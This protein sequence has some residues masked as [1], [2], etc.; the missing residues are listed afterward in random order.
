MKK[1]IFTVLLLI[2][3]LN[4]SDTF[5]QF[6]NQNMYLLKNLNQHYTTTL[7]AAVWGYVAPNGRE[8]AIL[9]CPTGTA[10]VDITDSANIHEVDFLTGLTSSWRE[11]KTYSHY[12]YIVSEATNSALQIVDLQ[13]L[14]DSVRLVKTWNYSGYT[15]THTISQSGHYLYLNGGN[16]TANGG[17]TVLDVIDPINPVKLG[18]WSTLYVHDCRVVND[19]IFAANINDAK[20]SIINA[21]NKSSLSSITSF[22]NLPGS[23]PHNT[24][25]T[26]N[27]KRLFVTDE[28]GNAP[29]LLKVWNIENLSNI[30]YVTSW[31]P[32]NITTSIVHNI[33]I[34]GNYALVAHYSAGVRVI[35]IS[36]P[37][38]PTE[39]AWYD[40]YP[41]NNN[42]SYNGCW[43]VYLFPSGK[44]AASDRQT[45]LY[46]LKTSTLTGI[47][48]NVNA[49]I[50][51]NFTLEQNYPNPF[52]PSTN[53]K[54]SLPMSSF[55]TLKVFD[56]AGNEVA[57][58]VN[59]KQNAGSYDINFDAGKNGLSSGIYFYSLQSDGFKQ[60]KKMILVK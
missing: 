24:A 44:I 3:S 4:V 16:A 31:Q 60:T 34:Y 36:N 25:V 7:Y 43:G 33:E 13:Y 56:A 41:S 54:Y 1:I 15:K 37:D 51:E 23:G 38:V 32:T 42:E 12:A 48:N 14:P 58:L 27:R 57:T 9:G 50:P 6:P 22:T 29:Y 28:I 55:V 30:T 2:L 52:N 45:G 53:I 8:Y 26:E 11:M 20:V 59:N 19:T 35:D 40:T 5:S 18:Q 17:I 49:A 10:F 21:T 47:Q 46:I 39:V